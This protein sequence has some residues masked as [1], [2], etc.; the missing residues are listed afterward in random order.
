MK[1][2][3]AILL[4]FVMA[5]SLMPLT[6]FAADPP[7]SGTITQTFSGPGI[8]NAQSVQISATGDITFSGCTFDNGDVL[9]LH[10]NGHSVT[11]ANCTF[12]GAAK[13][14]DG[15][16]WYACNV[17]GASSVTLTNNK[18]D[19]SYRGFDID[20]TGTAS[21][22]LT[23]TGNQIA[24][25]KITDP[26]LAEKNVGIQ[27]AGG[28]WAASGIHVT[29]NTFTNAT[30]AFRL[31][32]SFAFA[33]DGQGPIDVSG[34][35][36]ISVT[37]PIGI[38]PAASTEVTAARQAALNAALCGIKLDSQTQVNASVDPTYTIV[39]P[40][41]VDFGTLTKGNVTHTVS[42]P[43][44]AQNVLLEQGRQIDV[45]VTGSFM[46]SDGSAQLHYSLLNQ[47]GSNISAGK[48]CSFTGNG[49]NTGTVA[50]DTSLISQA[51]TYTGTMTFGF[52]YN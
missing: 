31:H 45:S 46:M 20:S 47:A 32:D 33:T 11:I 3:L 6:A 23:A 39:I 5:L 41:K 34:N 15:Y 35:K 36:M 14:A 13:R 38:D 26:A 25:T 40:A 10:A 4:T 30:T 16:L 18:V 7:T 22:A 17:F 29:G 49:T 8:D 27:V 37:D 43:V 21:T 48:Y 51:G 24:L 2:P 12:K 9:Y 44:E 50:V 1:K 42:F 52:A 19:G 28:G